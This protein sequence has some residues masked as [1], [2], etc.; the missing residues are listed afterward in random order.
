MLDNKNPEDEPRQKHSFIRE[1]VVKQPLTRRQVLFRAG[2]VILAAAAC[3]AA[4]GAM[5]AV[6]SP[7]AQRYLGQEEM[8]EST[9]ITI[10]R[11]EPESSAAEVSIPET[12]TTEPE[13]TKDSLWE[14][15]SFEELVQ[16]AIE[17]YEYTAADVAS[18]YAGLKTVVA[19][20]DH[21]I[22]TVHSVQQGLDWF[23]NP[24]ETSGLYAGVVIGSTAQEYLI[25]TP[26][27]AVEHADSIKV[28]FFD[29]SEVDGSIKQ[30]DQI[31]GMAMVSVQAD[32]LEQ[33]TKDNLVLL[34]LGN[35]YSVKQGDPV[36]A[37][38][39]PAGLVHSSAY[40]CISYVMRNV[41]VPDGIT[42]LLFADIR[43]NA[44]AGTFLLNL[45]G[46]MIG[47]VTDEYDNEQDSGLMTVRAISDYK[48]ILEKMSNGI[49]VPYL[50]IRGQE[51]STAMVSDGIPNGV[52]VA[53]C[54]QNGPAY[55]A[56]IQN[57]DVIVKIGEKSIST[58]KD[59][60]NQ[61]E[62]LHE[63]DSVTITVQRKSV[64]EY[65]EFEYQVIVGAR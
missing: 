19:G 61:L 45:N 54:I 5:F 34:P 9:E 52:Y 64:N 31:S 49:A 25:L 60:E 43:G 44:S 3:G 51:V 55:N 20:T 62:D 24:V 10:P 35:S 50:G 33:G 14:S 29:N 30:T 56:G 16:S 46:Q 59:Y 26:D 1:K 48:T 6:V 47:W 21:G 65:K 23:D 15:E 13:E 27:S 57:G 7:L 36:I 11:D 18:I 4:A 58:I 8:E 38:G 39:A 63:G 37:V 53:D 42:R 32:A 28:T 12:E 2:C 41:Q 17:N 40:G 22:V